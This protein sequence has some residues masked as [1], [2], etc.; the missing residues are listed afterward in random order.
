M[1]DRN[2]PVAAFET[3][4]RCAH[5]SLG[6]VSHLKC[7]F[8]GQVFRGTLGRDPKFQTA[9]TRRKHGMRH[10][11]TRKASLKWKY[12]KCENV[13]IRFV[14]HCHDGNGYRIRGITCVDD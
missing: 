11:L 5:G 8:L 13:E 12:I 6:E 4:A 9:P 1:D 7:E 3:G 2:P 14:D 10:Q